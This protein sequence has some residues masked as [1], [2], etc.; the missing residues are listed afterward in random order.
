MGENRETLR[1]S[2]QIIYQDRLIQYPFENDLSKLPETE[3][4]YCVNTFLNNPYENYIPQNM[5]QFFLKT[6]GEGITN[7]SSL[8]RIMKKYGNLTRV[9]MDY[10]WKRIP[11]PPR[12]DILKSAEGETI[13]GYT[14]QLYFSYPKENAINSYHYSISIT[15]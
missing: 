8:D 10:K 14:H 15:I 13:D 7:I 1:R 3:L 4:N 11:E 12:E 6:F 5:L 9:N 2:N